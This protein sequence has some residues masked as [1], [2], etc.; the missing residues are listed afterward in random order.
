MHS[1][2]KPCSQTHFQKE[3]THFLVDGQEVDVGLLHRQ[4]K[5]KGVSLVPNSCCSPTAMHKRTETQREKK[6]VN[7][8][9]A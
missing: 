6:Q 1:I 4:Q 7:F 2:L 8:C 5:D 3:V 9:E